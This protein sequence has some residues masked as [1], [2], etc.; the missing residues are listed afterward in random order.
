M[1]IKNDLVISE[2]KRLLKQIKQNERLT[3]DYSSKKS[4]IEI[5]VLKLEDKL[6]NYAKLRKY[7]N[8]LKPIIIGFILD[9]NLKEK[10]KKLDNELKLL[11]NQFKNLIKNKEKVSKELIKLS[12][13][14]ESLYKKLNDYIKNQNSEIEELYGKVRKDDTYLTYGNINILNKKL[15]DYSKNIDYL[16][17]NNNYFDNEVNDS[18]NKLINKSNEV[19]VKINSFNEEFVKR[20]KKE[21]SELFKTEY[22]LLDD[23]QQEAI[24]KDDKHNLVI[25]G[26][27]SGK[28]EVLTKRI[29][30]LIKRKPDTIKPEKILALAFQNKAA[31]EM[32]ERLKEYGDVRVQTFHSLGL[33]IITSLLKSKPKVIKSSKKIIHELLVDLR[34]SNPEINEL[35]TN[36]MESFDDG[37]IRKEPNPKNKQELIEF[38]EY[39]RNLRYTSLNGVPV[40]SRAERAIMNF[41]VM[42]NLNGEKID[43]KYEAPAEWMKYTNEKGSN[44]PT[45]DFYL[46]KYDIYIEHWA[47][48]KK[49]KVPKWFTVTTKE[50]KDTMNLKKQQFKEQDKYL[51]IETT[52]AEYQNNQLIE[53]L[54]K[55]LIKSLNEKYPEQSFEF[56]RVNFDEL[57]NR[58]WDECKKSVKDDKLSDDIANFIKIAKTYAL[59][60]GEVKLRLHKNIWL[61]KVKAFGEIAIKLYNKYQSY[62]NETNQIDFE[63]MINHAVKSL[64]E[65]KELYKNCFDHILIDEYQDINNQRYELI[66]TLMDKNNNCKLFCVGDD[67]QSIMGFS[68]SNLDLF[69][70]FEKYFKHPARTDLSINYRSNKTI[71]NAG[72]ALIHNNPKGSQIDKITISKNESENSICIYSLMHKDKFKLQYWNQMINHCLEQISEY[73]KLGYKNNEMMV[74]TRTLKGKFKENLVNAAYT[75]NVLL[76]FEGKDPSFIPLMTVHKSKGL[77]SKVVFILKVDDDLYGFPCKLDNPIIFMPVIKGKINDKEEEE[78]RLFYVGLTRSKDKVIMYTRDEA[79]SK[80]ISEIKDFADIH[81]V[82]Y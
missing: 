22:G 48:D 40:K 34:N 52:Q 41:F 71:V 75:K 5:D 56:V 78:R 19:N 45:P 43:V 14:K 33:G 4:K 6:K 69:V 81:Q 12:N 53:L 66:K 17:L 68:G 21:Y 61:D 76:S 39:M 42:H 26:A 57:I 1:I 44:T 27:G 15:E 23:N 70:N 60:P 25:A 37:Y 13:K 36:Y 31:N 74:L 11:N 65:N 47:L 2:I 51:L 3:K 7:S 58:V 80:F 54:K 50:Y 63:D 38:Y 55:R 49:E 64:K 16:K 72:S 18:I 29:A 79:Q 73:S 59:T 82:R 32:R 20:R 8:Y 62:C 35:I 46:P 77:Q 30:Y 9:N 10:S 28:T 24:I 67:W